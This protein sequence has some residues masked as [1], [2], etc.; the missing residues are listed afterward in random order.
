MRVVFSGLGALPELSSRMARARA[1]LANFRALHRSGGRALLN[2]IG[3]N[4]E[5]EGR[6]G[7][8]GPGGWP[9]LSNATLAARRRRGGRGGSMLVVS[10]RLKKGTNIQTDGGQ[11]RIFNPVPYASAHQ[12][13]LGVPRR[14]FFPAPRQTRAIVQ[15]VLERFVEEALS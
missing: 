5:S 15:P 9:P 13:G 14:P 1:R 7:S 6:L 8:G 10:G 12:F 3:R 11:A 2:W 4:F